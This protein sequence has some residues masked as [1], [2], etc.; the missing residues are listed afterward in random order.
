MVSM[1]T[2]NALDRRF[3]RR[4]APISSFQKLILIIS[5]LMCVHISLIAVISVLLIV[6]IPIILRLILRFARLAAKTAILRTMYQI[7]IAVL[8]HAAMNQLRLLT[9]KRLAHAM[10]N[11][12][13]ARA[14]ALKEILLVFQTA[15][16]IVQHALARLFLLQIFMYIP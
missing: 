14:N 6:M 5:A 11:I 10:M 16:L 7:T 9:V 12:L 2:C 8:S 15:L 13:L 4:L 3:A 1:S